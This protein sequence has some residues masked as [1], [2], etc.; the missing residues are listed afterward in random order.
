MTLIIIIVI[1]II[2]YSALTPNNKT[3]GE[4]N[5]AKHQLPNIYLQARNMGGLLK[6]LNFAF[7]DS[8]I[9][10]HFSYENGVVT[11]TMKNG[12]IMKAPLSDMEVSF[13]ALVNEIHTT[14]FAYGRKQKVITY[15]NFN[16]HEWEVI[17]RVL[18]L[19]SKTYGTSV[20]TGN[21]GDTQY[22]IQQILKE[23]NR[24]S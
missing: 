17:L 5:Q 16:K 12:T 23:L 3:Q 22:N 6:T 24:I 4:I 1:G 7:D 18:A 19:A 2:I 13:D 9:L 15:D 20:L 11:L 21:V 14:I 10:Q 8:V